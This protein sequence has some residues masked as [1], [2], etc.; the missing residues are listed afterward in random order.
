VEED[1]AQLGE[2]DRSAREAKYRAGLQDQRT[3]LSAEDGEDRLQGVEGV[4]V[5]WHRHGSLLV[6]E[7]PSGPRA[8]STIPPDRVSE[9]SSLLH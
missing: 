5:Q 2:R 7:L 6:R 3:R 1:G 4:V 8:S 9:D